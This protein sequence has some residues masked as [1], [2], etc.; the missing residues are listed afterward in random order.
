MMLRA[1]LLIVLLVARAAALAQ[2]ETAGPLKDDVPM[3]AYLDALAQIS[4]AARDGASAYLD[5][6]RRRCGRSLRA[7]E[8][9][10]A[11]TEGAGDPVLMAMM[12]AASL[13]DTATLQ[14][15]SDSV[16]C[17]RGK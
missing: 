4:P 17:M 16:R 2:S 7:I 13:R 8:L 5:A 9:R 1:L 12:R 3:D 10:Q 15:L 6:F 14:R 11:V